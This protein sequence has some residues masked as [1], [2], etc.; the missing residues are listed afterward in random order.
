MIHLFLAIA[1]VAGVPVRKVQGASG[2]EEPDDPRGYL[3]RLKSN[4]KSKA[5]KLSGKAAKAEKCAFRTSYWVSSA[6]RAEQ[7]SYFRNNLVFGTEECGDGD[8]VCVGDEWFLRPTP[9]YSDPE[10]ANELGT[11]T[12]IAHA[13]GAVPYLIVETTGTLSFDDEEGSEIFFSIHARRSDTEL[14]EAVYAGIGAFEDTRGTITQT[15]FGEGELVEL[16]ICLRKKPI[17]TQGI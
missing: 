9:F 4:V 10:L 1:V 6:V 12:S 7:R 14:R 16:D 8:G 5:R 2:F 11:M 13:V 15:D 17:T 3:R